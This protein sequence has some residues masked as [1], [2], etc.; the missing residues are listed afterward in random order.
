[1]QKNEVRKNIKINI[2]VTSTYKYFL[3]LTHF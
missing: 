3:F 1:M 2:Q